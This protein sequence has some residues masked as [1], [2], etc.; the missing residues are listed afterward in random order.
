MPIGF[1][2][3]RWIKCSP[4]FAQTLYNGH[5]PYDPG[6]VASKISRG[7]MAGNIG[8]GDKGPSQKGKGALRFLSLIVFPALTLLIIVV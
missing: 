8:Q 5:G 1:N 7:F 2:K 6:Y 3:C 4:Y